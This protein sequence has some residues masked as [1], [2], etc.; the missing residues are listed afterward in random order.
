MTDVL[1]YLPAAVAV[2][3]TALAITRANAVHALLYLIVSLLATGLVFFLLGAY[4]AALLEVIV[5]AGAVMVLF[6]FV[7]MMLGLGQAGEAWERTLLRPRLWLGPGLLAAVL[8]GEWML[9]FAAWPLPGALWAVT[10][11]QVG[12]ALLGPYVLAVELASMLLLA[13][14][15]GA[16]HLTR[17]PRRAP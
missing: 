12:I 15:V 13:G 17:L 8:L 10:A 9:A 1:F 3:A 11:K 16:Y 5:Y 6:L 14:L 4:F 2:I 7:L